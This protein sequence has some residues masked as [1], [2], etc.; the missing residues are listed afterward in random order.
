[1]NKGKVCIL[2]VDDEPRYIRAIQINLEASG[3]EVITARDGQT[4]IEL[5][6][7]EEPDLI[8]LDIRMGG[9]DGYEVCRRIREF[10]AVPIIMLTA[11]AEDADKVAGLDVGADDYVTKP[12]SADELLARV[13]AVLRRVELSERQDPSSTFQ[14]GDLLVDL[15]QQRV[16]VRGQEVNLT[17]TEYRLLCELVRQA[18]RVLVPEYLLEKVWGMGYEGE[19]RLL[20]QAIHRLRRKIERDPRN[21]QH[22]QT[23][24]GIGYVFALPQ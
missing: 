7:G 10:S 17:P 18:G 16:F 14:A 15:A 6:A 4:A 5:A 21:P 22:I 12:F 9:L 2:V 19:N 11:L 13:R 20:W 23:R 1:M 8:L 3:Y 24:P